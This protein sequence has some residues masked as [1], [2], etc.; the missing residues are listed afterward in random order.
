LSLFSAAA[1]VKKKRMK[2]LA[3]CYL[4]SPQYICIYRSQIIFILQMSVSFVGP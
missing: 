4:R 1:A 3:Q 2:K